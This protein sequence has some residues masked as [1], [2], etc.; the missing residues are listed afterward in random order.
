MMVSR[1]VGYSSAMITNYDFESGF[2]CYTLVE[3]LFVFK[4]YHICYMIAVNFGIQRDYL[5]YFFTLNVSSLIGHVTLLASLK[6]YQTTSQPVNQAIC[7]LLF[8]QLYLVILF[9]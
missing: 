5:Q 2:Q 4:G 6:C 1:V 7:I 3:R 8:D 9:Q